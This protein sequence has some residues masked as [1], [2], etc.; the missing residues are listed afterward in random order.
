M[1]VESARQL[2]TP[3]A[4]EQSNEAFQG[5]CVSRSFLTWVFPICRRSAEVEQL[6]VSDLFEVEADARP[7][8]QVKSFLDQWRVKVG[9]LPGRRRRRS[10]WLLLQVLAKLHV[11]RLSWWWMLRFVQAFLEF[12]FPLFLNLIIKFVEQ[13]DAPVWQGLL[14]CL[15][16]FSTEGLCGLVDAPA[17]IG[18][19]TAGLRI[20]ASLVSAIF[21]KV[22]LLRQD[23]MLSF[24]TGKLNNMI[25]T[26]VDK[27]KRA[28]RYLHVLLLTAPMKIFIALWSLHSLVG[29][30]VF[31]GLSWMGVVILLNPAMMYIMNRLEDAQQATTDERV[32]KVTEVISSINVI[33]C[34]GWEEPATAKVEVAR[35][36][37]LSALWRLYCLYTVFEGMWSSVVPCCTALMFASYSWLNP[38]KPLTPSQAFTAMSL[39]SM[40][41]DP[42]FTIP[43]VL[44]LLVEAF[45]AA[46][47]IEGLFWLSESS[48]PAI[49]ALGSFLPV[50]EERRQPSVASM[51][52][53]LKLDT[54]SAIRL[55]HASFVW[56]DQEPRERSQPT[57]LE[58]GEQRGDFQLHDLT[59]HVQ[60][61]SLVAVVGPTG[62]GK[63]SFLQALLGEM[64]K[65]DGSGKVEVSR[66]KPIAFVPQ[67]PWVFNATIRQ[68]ILFGEPYSENLY[69]ECL[70][71]SD[72]EQDLKNLQA[73][74]QTRVGEKGIALSGGQKARICLARAAY[75]MR[76]SSIYLLDDPYS[77][78]DSRVAWRCHEEMVA[79]QLSRKTRVV[80]MNRLEF[81][82][83][84]DQVVVMSNGQ[85]EAAGRYQEVV[86]SSSVLQALLTSQGLAESARAQTQMAMEPSNFSRAVS[87]GSAGSAADGQQREEDD[88]DD[89][90]AEGLEEEERATGQ[91][92]TEVFKYYF[93][94]MGG[95][96]PVSFL[97]ALYLGS[98]LVTLSLPVWLAVWTAASTKTSE[99]SL[100]Q[101]MHYLSVYVILS[102]FVIILATLRD[103]A[104]N[105]YGFMAARRLH[106]AMWTSVLRAPMS[107][108]QDT[109]QGRII[110]RFSKD[111]SEI[112]KEVIWNIINT[113]VPVL[114][115]VGNFAM[116]AGIAYYAVLAFLPAFYFYHKLW[117]YYNR[118]VLDVKRISKVQGSHVYDH[119]NNLCRENAISVVR[120]FRQA[121]QQC[122][123]SDGF[124]VD[125]QRPD[126]T[127]LFLSAWFSLRIEMLGSILTLLVS[128]F[129]A[130]GHQTLVSASTAALVLNF[131]GECAGSIEQLIGQVAEFSM[132]FNCVER[133]RHYAEELPSEAA[134]VAASRPPAGW[135]DRGVLKVKN[136]QLRYKPHL[137]LVLKGLSFSM[138]EG[139]RVGVVGRTGAGKSSLLLALLRIA[140]PELGSSIELD[141]QDILQ[142]GLQDLRRA[143]AMIPQ[144]PVL[145]QETLRYNCDP[146]DQHRAEDIWAALE[147]AQLAP[148][149]RRRGGEDGQADQ[150]GDEVDSGCEDR[151]S[152]LPPAQLQK[153]LSLEIKENG[154]NLSAGQRQMVAIAR[155]VLRSSKMVVLDEATA[156]V[157]ASTDE[158]LQK[159]IRRC[160]MGASSLT[161]AHRL[162]TIID[163]ERILVLADGQIA[164]FDSPQVLREKEHGVFRSMLDEVEHA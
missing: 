124:I 81:L 49:S 137:P 14:L 122:R 67:Q 37:E 97:A 161:I 31:I 92:Q 86:R 101:T 149:V 34:Y 60:K 69:R 162:Q 26:D 104:G 8:V 84:C 54:G 126:Y 116:V 136:L 33:K 65:K 77:A 88:E 66:A 27:A 154:Q 13:D 63:S 117:K 28:L 95:W 141:G 55:D 110:N 148:W 130:L 29:P 103:L 61:G 123:M 127:Q 72:L 90:E 155:A 147:E 73:G 41:Q 85:I 91:V 139:E 9:S 22:V 1:D 64:L 89:E 119:F 62:S 50:Q 20:R 32:R 30:S 2:D 156:A 105:V 111:M 164:E 53:P 39:L 114:G 93:R 19:Q 159:A 107:F 74:D 157:D 23:A 46:K 109:P 140:E 150:A 94:A 115:V 143:V 138:K 51:V 87:A 17:S 98:E 131:A 12:S 38:D 108:F 128:V 152:S 16:M 118:A 144:E 158:A 142:M 58:E 120:A 59:L 132:A 134:V 100:D 6:Q 52:P 76:D 133:V 160:F 99:V 78:L 135:P 10:G 25:T 40:V 24:S 35:R 145:F 71:S 106:L 102:I 44:N 153:L 151:C 57:S 80:A 129:I 68:N 121:E 146:F 43:W 112:D 45:V 5:N 18:L 15:A 75:R 4:A 125:Q 42:L 36:K 70:R 3:L 163:C 47:R 96:C 56:K 21:R 113:F 79:G 7:E 48:L 11:P 83:S 82:S